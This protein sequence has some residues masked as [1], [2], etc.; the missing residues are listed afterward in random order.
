MALG[1]CCCRWSLRVA[2]ALEF[3]GCF[4]GV[5]RPRKFLE[6]LELDG[7]AGEFADAVDALLDADQ[8]IVDIFDEAAVNG[9]E[10]LDLATEGYFPATTHRVVNPT[11]E[12]ARA[13]RMSMPLFLSPASEVLLA[14]GRTAGEFLEQ[15]IAELN[16]KG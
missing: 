8:G 13:A 11:G 16:R 5:A 6:A 1:R 2:A 9:G 12:A 10:M 7:L 14:Q 4:D 15:R 3:A